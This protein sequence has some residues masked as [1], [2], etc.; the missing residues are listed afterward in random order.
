MS[1][2]KPGAMSRET[3]FRNCFICGKHFSTTAD[4]PFV[5]QITNVNGK[6]QATVYF[7]SE[8]CKRKSYKHLFDGRAEE[9][10]KKREAKRDVREK[11]RKYYL[12]HAE[13]IK[14]KKK[15]EYSKNREYYLLD[16]KYNRQ[17]RKLIKED[18]FCER[19]QG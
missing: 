14:S 11:N 15:E 18:C 13:E 17:K 19:V 8:C 2:R 10:R 4:T 6:K 3:L 7:C 12:A 16:Q 5:R 9:R 1:V